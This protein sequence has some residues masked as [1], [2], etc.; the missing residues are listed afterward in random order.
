MER[1]I[2]KI[3]YI[4]KE[5]GIKNVF[6]R[7]SAFQR[8]KIIQR[9]DNSDIRIIM[10]SSENAASGTNLTKKHQKLYLLILFMELQIILKYRKS[11]YRT[12]SQNWSKRKY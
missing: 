12:Y 9:F 2:N 11:S 6:C 7:G 3:G 4:L 1:F 10:L 8:D 5:N